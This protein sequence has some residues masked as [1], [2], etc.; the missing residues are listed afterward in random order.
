MHKQLVLIAAV[1]LLG[2]PAIAGDFYV[3]VS[4][5]VSSIDDTVDTAITSSAPL[6]ELPDEFSLNGRPFD[7]NETA[8]GITIGWNARDWLAVELSYTDLGNTGQSLP[9]PF[10]GPVPLVTPAIR[11]NFIPPNVITV[12]TVAVLSNVNAASL[13]VE[14]WSIAARFR[15]SLI[16]NL[17]ANWS[18]GISRAHFDADGQLAILELVT[19]N[20]SVVNRIDVPYASPKSETGFNLGLGFEWRF[21]DRYSADIGYRRHDTRVIDVETVTLRLVVTL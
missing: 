11:P 16:S 6:G 1:L 19:L 2:S 9:T 13:E 10:I 5:G 14:E 17:S 12:P 8:S 20:P 18:V 15:K 4:V 3:G 21:S 7:S